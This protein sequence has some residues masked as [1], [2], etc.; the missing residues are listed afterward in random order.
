MARIIFPVRFILKKRVMQVHTLCCP[1]APAFATGQRFG[2]RGLALYHDKI[3]SSSYGTDVKSSLPSQCFPKI[4]ARF[5]V[6][7][8]SGC[9]HLPDSTRIDCTR[10]VLFLKTDAWNGPSTC[11]GFSGV[12]AK[13]N[14]PL[15][16]RELL[17]KVNEHKYRQHKQRNIAPHS[18][19]R[20]HEIKGGML[21]S[22][23]LFVP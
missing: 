18:K 17:K 7:L 6:S 1:K 13:R 15:P 22:H 11:P 14:P 23:F 9:P 5:T 16:D 4:F 8:T 19:T 10:D 3:V 12:K 20:V 2:P 21:W